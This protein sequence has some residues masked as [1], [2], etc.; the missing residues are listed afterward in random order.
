[1]TISFDVTPI[2]Q[3]VGVILGIGMFTAI[4]IGFLETL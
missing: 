1:M 3:F 2:I 4:T